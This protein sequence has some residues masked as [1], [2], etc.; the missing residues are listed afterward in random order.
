M[1]RRQ[2]TPSWDVEFPPN[3]ILPNVPPSPCAFDL[4]TGGG[5]DTVA[6]NLNFDNGTDTQH[7]PSPCVLDVNTGGGDDHVFYR[8]SLGSDQQTTFFAD[9]GEGDDAFLAGF[10][11]TA[12]LSVSGSLPDSNRI[13]LGDGDDVVTLD[14]SKVG[15]TDPEL[16]P[17]AVVDVNG[18]EGIDKLNVVLPAVQ[19]EVP[20]DPSKRSAPVSVTFDSGPG[21][22]SINLLG[23]DLAE[24]FD[25]TAAPDLQYGRLFS[26]D[27]SQ[28]GTGIPIAEIIAI[29]TTNVAVDA[30]GGDDVVKADIALDANWDLK[31]GGGDDTTQINAL[32]GAGPDDAHYT[33][34]ADEGDN[35]TSIHFGDGAN[36]RRPPQGK[37][38][39]ATYRSGAG[40][41]QV[42]VNYLAPLVNFSLDVNTGDGDD[43]I[44]VQHQDTDNKNQDGFDGQ[45]S[46][47]AVSDNPNDNRTGTQISYNINTGAGDDVLRL[48]AAYPTDPGVIVADVGIDLGSGDDSA[49]IDVLSGV[50]ET[51]L[52]LDL[53]AGAGNDQLVANLTYPPDPIH[54][55]QP[56]APEPCFDVGIRADLGDGDDVFDLLTASAAVQTLIRVNVNAGNGNDAVYARYLTLQVDGDGQ[57][58]APR[59]RVTEADIDLGDGNDTLVFE[60]QVGEEEVDLLLNVLGGGGRDQ[61]RADI[62]TSPQ[63][64]HPQPCFDAGIN[65]DLG[66]G[67]DLLNLDFAPLAQEVNLT[68]NV[69]AGGG[70]DRII[71]NVEHPDPC[72]FK[73]DMDF[74]LGGGNDVLGLL[75]NLATGQQQE[76][77]EPAQIDLAVGVHGGGGGDVMATALRIGGNAFGSAHVAM[78]GEG[79]QDLLAL[80][81]FIASANVQTELLIDGGPSK[82]ICMAMPNVEVVN[83]ERQAPPPLRKGIDQRRD[84]VP[85]LWPID[86]LIFG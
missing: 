80:L 69:S 85:A 20:N 5:Q 71:T 11:D 13:D 52:M 49:A 65:L 50:T 51:H 56:D 59:R 6:L 8:T 10:G 41:D 86:W 12:Q 73:A 14:L 72:F 29:T 78:Y 43:Q 19:N 46:Q 28:I 24:Q 31:L 70:A 77:S 37:T 38:V 67:N 30:A 16:M 39:T 60:H 3:P 15:I 62:G 2:F 35:T 66:G 4:L 36:G 68:I 33:V 84:A 47:V 53:A 75:V 22:D 48:D 34:H 82:D 9:L 55:P 26:F 44:N 17:R 21:D 7:P 81:A 42:E 25:I 32:I 64:S 54:P 76:P 79:G 40:A 74:D 83:C 1:S 61:V 63:A 23:S 58:L 57:E 27:V 45:R 18:G